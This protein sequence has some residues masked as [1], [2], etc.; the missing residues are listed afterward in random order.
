MRNYLLPEK[1]SF[2]KANLHSH[3]TISDGALSPEEMKELYKSNGYA[4]LAYTDHDLFLPHHDLTD[5]AFLALAGFE[6][7]FYVDRKNAKTKTCHVCFIAKDSG[8]EL[9]PCWNPQYAMIGNAAKYVDQVK[10]DPKEPL[11]ER[12]YSP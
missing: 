9:Q 11:F 4:V 1:G 2:F 10:F 12:E 5:E 8:M 7:E 6:A 3:T